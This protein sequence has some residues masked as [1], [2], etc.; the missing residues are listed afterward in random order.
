MVD[1]SSVSLLQ[2]PLVHVVDVVCHAPPSRDS[3]DEV[4]CSTQV[5]IPRRGVFTARVGDGTVVADPVTAMVLPSG[6]EY[7]VTHPTGGGDDCTV[8]LFGCRAVTDAF[9]TERPVHGRVR[10]LSQLTAGL[11]RAALRRLPDDELMGEEGAFLLL[12]RLADDL[13]SSPGEVGR[14]LGST[15]RRRVDDA[16]ELLA[17]DPAYPW[18]L[19]F[20]AQQLHCSPYHLA[21]QFHRV[22]GETMWQYVTRLRLA[23]AL[24]EILD[25]GATL[26]DVAVRA[27]FAHHSHLTSAFR[28]RFAHTPSAIRTR[29]LRGDASELGKILTAADSGGS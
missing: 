27:G 6:Q 2:T 5:V 23:Q 28:K 21:R 11:L 25:G 24:E 9:G 1:R 15:Q 3:D 20:V 18:R 7:R 26:G 17:S 4:A 10:P 16:R 13:T 12:Q 22:S 19:T 14:H 8:L 29:A